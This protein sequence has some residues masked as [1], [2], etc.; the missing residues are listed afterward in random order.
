MFKLKFIS[1]A[2]FQLMKHITVLQLHTSDVNELTVELQAAKKRATSSYSTIGF[3]CKKSY[4]GVT[5]YKQ[6]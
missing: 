1:F 2:C 4:T 3:S 6:T 5:A